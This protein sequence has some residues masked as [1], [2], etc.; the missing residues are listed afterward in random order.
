MI[1]RAAV[2]AWR[3]FVGV[4]RHRLLEADVL[5]LWAPAVA[6]VM[7]VLPSDEVVIARLVLKKR[8]GRP[9]DEHVREL[10]RLKRGRE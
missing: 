1:W 3:V 10:R 6:P 8:T 9:R 2:L 7:A 4:V 5:R